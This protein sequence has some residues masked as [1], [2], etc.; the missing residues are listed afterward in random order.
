MIKLFCNN[1]LLI[2]RVLSA[3][4]R[5]AMGCTFTLAVRQHIE[6]LKQFRFQLVVFDLFYML[7][8]VTK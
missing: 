1:S 2:S 5:T 4:R 7:H 3:H 8:I 6:K